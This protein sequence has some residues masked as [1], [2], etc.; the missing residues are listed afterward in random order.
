MAIR[1]V[2]EYLRLNEGV[3]FISRSEKFA[4]IWTC[5]EN[6][7]MMR[8]IPLP[9]SACSVRICRNPG[10]S[11]HMLQ[12]MES[13]KESLNCYRAPYLEIYGEDALTAFQRL[14]KTEAI[15]KRTRP[16]PITLVN[17]VGRIKMARVTRTR[18]LFLFC[19]N[20]THVPEGFLRL[21][22]TI[23]TCL[24]RCRGGTRHPPVATPQ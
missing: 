8:G 21:F 6:V 13:T 23:P 5:I 16:R 18:G 20:C 15:E 10:C 4:Q 3:F 11:G 9:Q 14:T 12:P 24:G 7:E 17:V 1:R 19:E 22:P 2:W